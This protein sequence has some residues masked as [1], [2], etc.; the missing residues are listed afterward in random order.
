[1]RPGAVLNRDL[2]A[3]LLFAACGV[4]GLWFGRDLPVGV[5]LRMGPGYVPW[6][7]SWALIV[8]GSVIAIKGAVAGGEPLT[9]WNL[10]PLVLLPL[11]LLSFAVLIEP[12]GLPIAALAVVLIGAVAGP[13]FRAAEVV[14]LAVSLAACSIGLFVYALGLPMKVLPF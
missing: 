2:L 10:R 5:A 12:A 4:A 11:A 13:E 1:M 6:L 9:R 7:L 14:V 8:I 3:G